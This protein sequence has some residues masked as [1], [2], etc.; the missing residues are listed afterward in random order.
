MIH[1]PERMGRPS[2][3]KKDASLS[4]FSRILVTGA[5]GFVGRYLVPVLAANMGTGAEIILGS[6]Y[7]NMEATYREI[8]FDLEDPTIIASAIRSTRPD[9]VV[10]LAAQASVGEAGANA[11]A[12]WSLNL[13][14]SLALGR[15]VAEFSPDCTF[16]YVSSAEVYGRTFNDGI[17]DEDSPL[18]PQSA[19]S[20]SKAAAEGMLLDLLPKTARLIVVRPSNHSGPGQDERFVIPAFAAQIARIEAGGPPEIRVGNLEANRDFLDVRDVVAA[21]LA[22][23]AQAADL[24]LRSTFN[25]SSGCVVPIRALLDMLIALSPDKTAQVLSDPGRMRASEV[26]RAEIDASRLREVTGWAPEHTI[27]DT[28]LSVLTAYRRLSANPASI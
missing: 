16:F 21:Y 1:R 6:R 28:L 4:A 14:G 7:P 15:A 25:I 8:A 19:Y 18:R 17:A 10:H 12:T 27:Q 2:P 22:L 20:R 3:T 24:P 26:P 5:D 23:L 9:L 11:A 13:C